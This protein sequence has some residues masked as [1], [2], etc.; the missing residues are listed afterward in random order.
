[1]MLSSIERDLELF[2][3]MKQELYTAVCC[4][5]MD[6]FGYRE[7][8]MRHNIRPVCDDT[9]VIGRAKTLLA[10][11]VQ[12]VYANPYEKEIEA[13]DSVEVGQVVV[14]D[15]NE[16]TASGIWG[17]LLSTAALM[18]G[19]RGAVVDGLSRDVWK[20][21]KMSFPLFAVGYR[22]LD[23]QGR[24][25]IFD[26]DCTIRCGG[27]KVEPNDLIFGDIDGVI[28]IPKV[29][30]EDVIKAAREKVSK[31]NV[32]R[33]ELLDGKLLKEVYHKYGVL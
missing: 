1:M 27:V 6:S 18:R 32:T 7:Q 28:V 22:P 29:I 11:D 19:G 23:S 24:S 30:A 3:L 21:R 33:K 16:S 8:A 26:Y 10:A 31:E 9:V 5:V 15:T 2:A 4:D 12:E 14:I 25:Y 13:L 17:E 20:I